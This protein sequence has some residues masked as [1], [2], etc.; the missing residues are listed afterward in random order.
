[1]FLWLF[2]FYN[3]LANVML[4]PPHWRTP[5]VSAASLRAHAA[6]GAKELK[7]P[8]WE[9]WWERVGEGRATISVSLYLVF[10]FADWL[11]VVCSTPS[12]TI[13]GPH[14]LRWTQIESGDLWGGS[15]GGGG[16]A[17]AHCGCGSRVSGPATRCRSVPQNV[18]IIQITSWN[19]SLH[20]SS[21]CLHVIF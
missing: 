21:M 10:P 17:L 15:S 4:S 5:N 11:T 6:R 9:E 18:R 8:L 19:M 7:I 20:L 13:N 3:W 16:S 14:L 1:M 2:V 12:Q